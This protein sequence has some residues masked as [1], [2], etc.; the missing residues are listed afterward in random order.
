MDAY[1]QGSD[2]HSFNVPQIINPPPQIFGAYDTSPVD[3]TF[4]PNYFPDDQG[5]GSVDESTEAKR[6][7]IARVKRTEL[8]DFLRPC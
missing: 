5:G 2:E 1:S 8:C 3:T 7:R 4:P 6:R